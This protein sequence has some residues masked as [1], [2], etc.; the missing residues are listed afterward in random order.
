MQDIER[1]LEEYPEYPYHDAFSIHEL[2]QK[3]IEHVL[4]HSPHHD[5]VEGSQTLPSKPNV[6]RAFIVAER[7]KMETF[8]HGSMLHI[9]RENANWLSHRLPHA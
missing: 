2:R 3:L 7:I 8:V 6:R 9:L 5:V 4:I 1:V